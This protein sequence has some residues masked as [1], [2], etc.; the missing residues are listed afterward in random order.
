[1]AQTIDSMDAMGTYL[2]HGA[3]G[4]IE[5]D[6]GVVI[7]RPYSN[8]DSSLEELGIEARIFQHLGSHSRVVR[9]LSWVSEQS[10]LKTESLRYG[11]LKMFISSK[12][13]STQ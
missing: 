9:F 3:S 6:E 1:M 5:R 11:N 8:N 4:I 10:I 12:E 7:K 2:A 13:S